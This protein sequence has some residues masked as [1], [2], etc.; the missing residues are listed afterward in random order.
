MAQAPKLVDKATL[1]TLVPPQSL[2]AENFQELARKAV[3][4]ELPGGRVIFKKGDVDRKAV[5]VLSG[6]V[7]LVGESG[8]EATITGGSK[9]AKHPLANQQ[10]R[11]LTA[12]TK[13]SVT[14]TRF[15]SDLLDILLT[16]DQLSGIEVSD[17]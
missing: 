10:P 11:Q 1:K 17:I 7:E 6:E 12:R 15:D 16:W 4:E 3:L 2:N 13:G 8:V 9:E 5:Y 14:L